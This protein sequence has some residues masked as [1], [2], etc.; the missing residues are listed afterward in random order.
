MSYTE[1]EIQKAMEEAK[2]TIMETAYKVFLS[3]EII[4]TMET[5]VKEYEKAFMTYLK[6]NQGDLSEAAKWYC[7]H[8]ITAS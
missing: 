6:V 8:E 4:K 7:D 3:K 5:A 2:D 1:K